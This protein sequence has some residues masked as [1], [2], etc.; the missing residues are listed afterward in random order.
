M[1]SCTFITMWWYNSI[2]Y[3]PFNHCIQLSIKCRKFFWHSTIVKIIFTISKIWERCKKF[4]SLEIF[5]CNFK[6][7]IDDTATNIFYS[8]GKS[9]HP[10]IIHKKKE[11]CM[12]NLNISKS[13][14]ITASVPLFMAKLIFAVKSFI[15]PSLL[16][17]FWSIGNVSEMLMFH[18]DGVWMF[19]FLFILSIT[20]VEQSQ[21]RIIDKQNEKM[22][23]WDLLNHILSPQ[24]SG[25]SF[26]SILPTSRDKVY[27]V[28]I[29][30]R[31]HS[32]FFHEMKVNNDQKL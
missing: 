14:F 3:I 2:R 6:T 30:I 20:I 22:I 15:H 25:N 27:P 28:I 26:L 32:K 5:W 9:F 8:S 1:T 4:E 13:F 10:L 11:F 18:H 23:R 24:Q 21:S 29:G 12:H 19:G 16:Y 7:L 17:C 31:H